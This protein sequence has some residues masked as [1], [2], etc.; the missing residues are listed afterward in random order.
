[1]ASIALYSITGLV[2]TQANTEGKYITP[3]G[4]SLKYCQSLKGECYIGIVVPR[5]LS[6][7]QNQ[8]FRYL[9]K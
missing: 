7:P 9:K 2:D 6:I 1:M 3:V 8:L 4:E 5:T